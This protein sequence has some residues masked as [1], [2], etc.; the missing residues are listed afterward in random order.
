MAFS[1]GYDISRSSMMPQRFAALARITTLLMTEKD[2]VDL[3]HTTVKTAYDASQAELAICF[4]RHVDE[5]GQILADSFYLADSIGATKQVAALA[6][7]LVEQDEDFLSTIFQR[8][9]PVSIPDMHSSQ[10]SPYLSYIKPIKDGSFRLYTRPQQQHVSEPLKPA[11]VL[12]D[13]SDLRSLLAVPLFYRQGAVLGGLLLAHSATHHFTAEDEVLMVSLASTTAVALEND[14]LHQRI[15]ADEMA[16]QIHE[17]T[18]AQKNFLQL[19]FDTLPDSVFLLRG[20]DARLVMMNQTAVDVWKQPWHTGQSLQ[21]FFAESH[22][23]VVDDQGHI[24]PYEQLSIINALR[25]G[26][27]TRRRPEHIGQA[28]GDYLS[29]MTS[30]SSLHLENILTHE[31]REK[32]FLSADE[33][34]VVAVFNDVTPLKEAE[35]MKDD[36]LALAAHELR[37][38]LAILRGLTQTL[39]IQTQRGHGPALA[40]WQYETIHGIDQ[41]TNRMTALAED[42]LDVARVQAGRIKLEIV[43]CDLVALV[44]RVTLRMQVISARHKLRFQTA[45]AYLV[46]LADVHRMEQVLLNLINNAIKYS[47]AG[48]SIEICVAEEERSEQQKMAILSVRDYGIGIPAQQQA[49]IFGRFARADNARSVAGTGLGLYLC[50]ALVEQQQGRI[51]FESREDQGSTFFVSLPVYST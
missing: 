17:V 29:V 13:Q 26:T 18:E 16:R 4:L 36:F 45:L 50:R 15:R 44:R 10:S 20:P 33:P 35:R 41:V 11:D 46:V 14:R 49:I 24:I 23:V 2:S 22:F 40:D 39:L 19:I 7:R 32:L 37:S 42:L 28:G 6:H 47:P 51:W 1:R 34:I 27:L 25:H 8:G 12:L 9:L 3:I 30:V 5:D 21:E 38:P 48:G 31:M 43:P